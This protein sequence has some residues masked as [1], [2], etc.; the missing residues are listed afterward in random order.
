MGA[1]L[2]TLAGFLIASVW[3]FGAEE[4]EGSSRLEQFARGG[5]PIAVPTLVH[6]VATASVFSTV[7]ERSF[8][9]P[10]SWL[11]AGAW[12]WLALAVLWVVPHALGR[13]WAS[14]AI[15]GLLVACFIALPPLTAFA[16]YFVLYP[17][18]RSYA[19]T[20]R[21]SRQR[22]PRARSAKRCPARHTAVC[23]DDCHRRAA[24]A[25]IRRSC[26]RSPPGTHSAGLGGADAP[27]H[28]A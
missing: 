18:T 19:G 16:I 4:A 2:W 12:V 1:P 25:V 27:S 7:T 6:P 22:P 3:H 23:D 8:D 20:D 9:L 28:A 24:L 11:Q 17:R 21:Q 13:R 26:A 14:L 5:L 15:P 10:P